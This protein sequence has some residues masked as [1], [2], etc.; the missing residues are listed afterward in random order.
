MTPPSAWDADTSPCEW[1]G[2]KIFAS[3]FR[4]GGAPQGRRGHDWSFSL[5]RSRTSQGDVLTL[6]GLSY[7]QPCNTMSAAFSPIMIEGALVLPEVSVGMIEASATRSPSMPCTRSR[8][9]TTAIASEPILQ[10]PT[11]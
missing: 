4:W 2:T 11:G 1:G 6:P 3:P 7:A 8:A 10:V 9:S 5:R